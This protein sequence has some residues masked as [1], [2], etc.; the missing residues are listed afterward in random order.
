MTK[1]ASRSRDFDLGFYGRRNGLSDLM[2]QV[3]L[4][5]PVRV[6]MLRPEMVVRRCVDQLRINMNPGV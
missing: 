1:K 2:L 6:V 5:L 3:Q 4:V